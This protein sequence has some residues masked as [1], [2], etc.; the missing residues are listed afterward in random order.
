MKKKMWLFP[1]SGEQ[2]CGYK[3]LQIEFQGYF[4][5]QNEIVVHDRIM[6]STIC[7]SHHFTINTSFDDNFNSVFKSEIW[8]K[9]QVPLKKFAEIGVVESVSNFCPKIMTKNTD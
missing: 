6:K 5:W 2:F 7:Q 4:S 9:A 8:N 3:W 1:N